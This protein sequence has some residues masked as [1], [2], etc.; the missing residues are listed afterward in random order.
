MKDRIV[1]VAVIAVVE[2][3]DDRADDASFDERGDLAL[4]GDQHIF[5]PYIAVVQTGR[6]L[7]PRAS[8][9]DEAQ[10][11]EFGWG[12]HFV[13][14]EAFQPRIHVE[15]LIEKCVPRIVS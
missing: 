4:I 7:L 9:Q 3:D 15:F 1:D 11:P 13:L 8:F 6:R 10:F 5:Q 14:P 12:K 2:R